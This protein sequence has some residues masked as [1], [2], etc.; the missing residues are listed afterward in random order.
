MR[1]VLF[2]RMWDLIVSVPDDCLSFY[3]ENI[4]LQL[5]LLSMGGLSTFIISPSN[6]R[7][8]LFDFKARLPMTLKL[9]NDPQV[10]L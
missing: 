1:N 3:I 9:P 4:R 2:P 5:N 8:L 6:L 7:H 10:D